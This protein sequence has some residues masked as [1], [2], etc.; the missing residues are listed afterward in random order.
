MKAREKLMII[1][2]V[3][4]CGVSIA[5]F[6]LVS[7][8]HFISTPNRTV[9]PVV[10]K[11]YESTVQQVAL[12]EPVPVPATPTPVTNPSVP[13]PVV[14]E[15]ANPDDSKKVSHPQDDKATKHHKYTN[16]DEDRSDEYLELRKTIAALF[17]LLN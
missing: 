10:G 15:Y 4:A 14:A 16:A 13:T 17:G 8:G 11:M 7:L 9:L 1:I 6:A 2:S 5:V 12:L 3:V